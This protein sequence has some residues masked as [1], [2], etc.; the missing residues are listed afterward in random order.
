MGLFKCN[1]DWKR[2]A[3]SNVLQ[4]DDMGYPLRLYICK[5]TKCGKSDQMWIDVSEKALK[6]LETGESVL[7]KWEKL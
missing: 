2:T 3:K 6:E 4:L 5:C 1:H 7:L